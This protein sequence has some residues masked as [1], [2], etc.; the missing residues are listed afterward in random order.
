MVL[1]RNCF[2]ENTKATKTQLLVALPGS[3]LGNDKGNAKSLSHFGRV[4]A[5]GV[6]DAARE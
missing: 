4:I 3:I 1:L 2:V 5:T 6:Y